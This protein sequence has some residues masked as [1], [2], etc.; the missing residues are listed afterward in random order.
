VTGRR[1]DRD[2]LR[3]V[4]RGRDVKQGDH[5]SER[6][7]VSLEGKEGKEFVGLLS[8]QN[9]S[10]GGRRRLLFGYQAKACINVGRSLEF[11]PTFHELRSRLLSGDTTKLTAAWVCL[12]STLR[13]SAIH[14][15]EA[16]L[17]AQVVNKV[18]QTLEA[19]HLAR[20]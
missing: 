16:D 20:V 9:D 13:K 8:R 7:L 19:S 14:A 10:R 18:V 4:G 15:C 2:V 6:R 17:L 5:A 11:R 12:V 1:P 3:V